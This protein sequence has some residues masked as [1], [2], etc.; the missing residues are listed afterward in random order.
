MRQL[1]SV[2]L[3]MDVFLGEMDMAVQSAIGSQP[4]RL[5]VGVAACPW[6]HFVPLAHRLER[7]PHG[8]GEKDLLVFEIKEM[9]LLSPLFL[10]RSTPA[11]E[12]VRVL[13][14]DL[15]LNRSQ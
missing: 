3:V 7:R 1:V 8:H 11:P 6:V 4:P 13:T 10:H 12:A 15:F 14:L 9:N 2:H 5:D